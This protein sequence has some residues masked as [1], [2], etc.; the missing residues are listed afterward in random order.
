MR[1]YIIP[2]FSSALV[3]IVILFIP[4]SPKKKQST[5]NVE[6]KVRVLENDQFQLFYLIDGMKG[7]TEE[8]ST[9]ANVTGSPVTQVIKFVI[10]FNKPISKIRIDVGQNMNQKPIIFESVKFLIS[11][12]T[13]E[14]DI[15][16]SFT[17]NDYILYKDGDWFTKIRQDLQYPYDPYFV[18]NF[19]LSDSTDLL[20]KKQILRWRLINFTLAI[21]FSQAILLFFYLKNI[22][23]QRVPL[24]I[25]IVVFLLILIT[26]S[27]VKI[28]KLEKDA[29]INEKRE[30][31]P[32]PK[33]ELTEEFS[34]KYENYYNDN[35]SLRP[36]L[37][38]WASK[39]KVGLFNVSTK[40]DLVQ[41]GKNGFL[42]Y[43][44]FVSYSNSNIY[45]E[46]DLEKAYQKQSDLKNELAKGKCKYIIGF[47]PDKHTVYSEDLPLTM[48]MQIKSDSSFAEKITAYFNK[49]GLLLFNVS[50]DLKKSKVKNQLYFKFDTH[51]NDNG[52]FEAYKSFCKQT[53]SELGLT[54]LNV[55]NFNIVDSKINNGDLTNLMGINRISRYYDINPSYILRD[56]TRAYKIID[57][58]GFPPLTVITTND[59]CD[60]RKVVLVFCD[61]FMASFRQF[62]SLHYYKIFYIWSYPLDS[63]TVDQ[64]AL[65]GKVKP[66]IVINCCVERY[67]PDLL[68]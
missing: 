43:N 62:L 14:F 57:S 16:K 22:Q 58:D 6:L 35:F 47:Y 33:L 37:I 18:S 50:E 4:Y 61:S 48:K 42:F 34:H 36:T 20:A 5:I 63:H 40:P 54:A 28:L 30:L 66:D 55:D 25:F 56:K 1:R 26:P 2:I 7:F 41:F 39:I 9:N 45:S 8:E 10:P 24:N 65:M 67:L 19:N 13:L 52:V 46:L 64:K 60:N 59:N 29:G 27:V 53:F 21:I 17:P 11:N 49:R 44:S 3:F 68:Q 31:S 12:K 38:K 32:K 51:W 15:S 23:F